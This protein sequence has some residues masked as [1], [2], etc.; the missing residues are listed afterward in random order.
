MLR[1]R[2][3]ADSLASAL[4]AANGV[5]CAAKSAGVGIIDHH[6]RFHTGETIDRRFAASAETI[7][8]SSQLALVRTEKDGKMPTEKDGK[9]RCHRALVAPKKL[10]L[11][12]PLLATF[13]ERGAEL[14]RSHTTL[15]QLQHH[16]TTLA[17]LQHDQI[18]RHCVSASE[19]PGTYLEHATTK[20]IDGAQSC[21]DDHAQILEL[22]GRD[23][24]GEI[25]RHIN[26]HRAVLRDHFG[27][28]IR[29]G[30]HV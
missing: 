9:T 2:C 10:F 22:F 12:E 24:Q 18:H 20:Q 29:V 30:P 5:E 7:D 28:N 4:L 17:Q 8:R 6:C 13:R 23:A 16:H 15:A 25:I 14:D 3:S 1:H 27:R 21:H 19:L 11:S 26:K